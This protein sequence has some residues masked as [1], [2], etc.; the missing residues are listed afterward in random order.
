MF[1]LTSWIEWLIN[2][3]AIVASLWA[4]VDCARRRPDAFPAIGRQTK[5][6]WLALTGASVLVA[7]FMFS[8][9]RMLGIAAMVIPAIYLLDIRPRILEITGGR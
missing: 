8:P 4:F 5:P 3:A 9:F 7:L 6:I 2:V 1:G